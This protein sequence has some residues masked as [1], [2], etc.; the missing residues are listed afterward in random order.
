MTTI[1]YGDLTP[2]TKVEKA[3]GIVA[4]LF[5]G[6]VFAFAITNLVGLMASLKENRIHFRNNMDKLNEFIVHRKLPDSLAHRLRAFWNHKHRR[7]FFL[8]R[9]RELLQDMSQSLRYDVIVH[10]KSYLV[11]HSTFCK[12]TSKQ[13]V[14]D[15]V[16]RLEYTCAVQWELITE[17]DNAD[18]KM[19]ILDKGFV[20]LSKNGVKMGTVSP[21]EYFGEVALLRENSVA[22]GTATALAAFNDLSFIEKWKFQELDRM[23]PEIMKKLKEEVQSKIDKMAII[24]ANLKRSSAKMDSLISERNV[25]V[26]SKVSL[27]ANVKQQRMWNSEAFAFEDAD[28][29]KS[30]FSLTPRIGKVSGV[31]GKAASLQ[32]KKRAESADNLAELRKSLNSEKRTPLSEPE[33]VKFEEEEIM[34]LSLGDLETSPRKHSI[35]EPGSIRSSLS[36][37]YLDI[38]S[39]ESTEDCESVKHLPQLPAPSSSSSSSSTSSTSSTSSSSSSSSSSTSSSSSSTSSTSS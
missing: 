9:E 23:Y 25:L 27:N 4:M 10:L 29:H 24:E 35:V 36:R 7:T 22:L 37:M 5:G 20:G 8:Q 6:L 3:A 16:M 18:S 13:F 31:F 32:N 21:G 39:A 2:Q 1:G 34:A 30:K 14:I 19:Y 28:P 12:D 33:H 11:K 26:S 38:Q 17:E 15:F